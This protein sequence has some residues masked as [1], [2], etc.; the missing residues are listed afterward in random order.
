[1][2][3][4]LLFLQNHL[5]LMKLSETFAKQSWSQDMN[6][7]IAITANKDEA[8]KYNIKN[9]IEFDK[10]IG[11]RYSIWSD[12]SLAATLKIIKNKKKAFL[13]GGNQAD[14]DLKR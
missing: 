1:M 14:L 11:G 3:Q 10:E 6:N 4:F 13:Q 2:I 12:I 7:F 9:I 5:Q 8:N